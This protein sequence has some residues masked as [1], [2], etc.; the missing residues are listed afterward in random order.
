MNEFLLDRIKPYLNKRLLIL[1]IGNVLRSDDGF[2]VILARRLKRRKLGFP[3]WEVGVGL[4][5]Y[6]D[7]IIRYKPQ[8]LLIFEAIDFG[9]IPGQIRLSKEEELLE[10]VNI[11]F[12]HNLSILISINYLQTN[13]NPNIII[14]SVQPKTTSFGRILTPEV[15]RSVKLIEDFFIKENNYGR[16][17]Y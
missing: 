5:N 15:E 2:G 16:G 10:T 9:G 12:T 8:T 3:I 1:G 11:G 14:L 4:E 6:L 13:F 17:G 7:K